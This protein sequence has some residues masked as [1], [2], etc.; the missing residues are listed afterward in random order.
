M[1]TIATIGLDIAKSVF[2]IHGIDAAGQVVIRRQLNNGPSEREPIGKD[3]KANIQRGAKTPGLDQFDGL[4][5]NYVA[6]GAGSTGDRGDPVDRHL[7]PAAR[8]PQKRFLPECRAPIRRKISRPLR[9]S[10]RIN[11]SE[12]SRLC[13]SPALTIELSFCQRCNCSRQLVAQTCRF[14]MSAIRSLPG[15]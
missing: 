12:R 1:Q 13:Y 4:G 8:R 5:P 11:Q 7:V 3:A 9:R 10:R 2:Q 14:V 15:E 6:Q